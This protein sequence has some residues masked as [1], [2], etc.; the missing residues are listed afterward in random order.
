MGQ[1]ADMNELFTKLYSVALEG[2]A[3]CG[4]L[5]SYNY[6]SGEPVTGFDK[7]ALL[8]ARGAEGRFSLANLMR[9]HLYSA[10]GALKSGMDLLF[11]SED[12]KIDEMFGHGGYFKTK[13]VGQKIAAAAVG[14]PVSV[15]E[16]AGEGGAWGIA[17]LAAY[18][19]ESGKD[20]ISL[21]DYLNKEIFAGNKGEKLAAS[22]EETEGFDKFMELYLKGLNM[23]KEAVKLFEA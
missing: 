23:E 14:A 4:G 12:V 6:T 10:L 9:M 3:D 2:D 13:G 11:K 22:K 17:L 16:T 7:G 8:F 18:M 5:L 1:K 15:M 19:L 20:A 21:G